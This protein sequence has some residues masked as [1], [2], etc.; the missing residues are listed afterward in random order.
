MRGKVLK[1]AAKRTSAQK[2]QKDSAQQIFSKRAFYNSAFSE[3]ADIQT[4]YAEN[5]TPPAIPSTT[6]LATP[7]NKPPNKMPAI[8]S[9]HD[10][11]PDTLDRV[12]SILSGPLQ[13]FDPSNVL[14]LVVPGG[15]W[16]PLQIARLR[17]W[18]AQGYELAGHGWTHQ[19]MAIRTPYHWLHSKL[20]SRRAAEHLSQK[21]TALQALLMRNAQWFLDKGF[22]LPAL[23]V[24]P[25]WALGDLSLAQLQC[26]PFQAVETLGGLFEIA[27]GCYYALPLAGYEADTPWRAWI[28]G[29]FNRL[30]YGLVRRAVRSRARKYRQDPASACD[31]F[32]S[33]RPLRLAIHPMDFEYYLCAELQHVLRQ[34]YTVHWS[35]VF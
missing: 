34:V 17:T 33:V 18:Q 13:A 12:E 28:L 29:W 30:A 11:M 25:A 16:Q 20:L 35:S 31:A 4:N 27:S 5:A 32:T 15:D 23:Y 7:S 24:P 6:P 8:V 21:S 10:V 26:S 3:S 19:V 14:L 1:S 22:G 9:V 2:V